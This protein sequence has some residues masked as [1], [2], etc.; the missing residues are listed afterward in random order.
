MS[1]H[2]FVVRGD[3]TRFACDAWLIPTGRGREITRSFWSPRDNLSERLF[4][5][6]AFLAAPGRAGTAAA[7]EASG[8][9]LAVPVDRSRSKVLGPGWSGSSAANPGEPFPG[10]SSSSGGP[11]PTRIGSCTR[12][13]RGSWPSRSS[14][15]GPEAST[16][17]QAPSSPNCCRAL[18]LEA[19]RLDVDIALVAFSEP[20]HAA[21]QAVRRATTPQ[22]WWEGLGG[23]AMEEARRLGRFAA[24]GRLV[25][26]F[27]AGLSMGVGLPVV[28][29]PSGRPR[30]GGRH[31]GR[32]APTPL[33]ARRSRLRADCGPA[34]QGRRQGEGE[35]I[36][37]LFA[38]HGRYG[39]SHGAL[40]SLPVEEFITT[41]YDVLF[42]AASADAGRPVAVLPYAPDARGGRW[43]LKMHGC[44]NH[45]DDVVLTR[46]SYLRYAERNA[47]LAGIVQAMLI[48]R[49]MLFLGFSLSD[50]NFHRIVDAVRRALRPGTTVGAPCS[51]RPSR[52][53]P[54]DLLEHLWKGEIDALRVPDGRSV[55]IF[56]DRLAFEAT[57][58]SHLLD[59]R[60]DALLEESDLALNALLRPLVQAADGLPAESPAWPLVEDLLVRLGA[61][62]PTTGARA[63]R[64]D[65]S[66]G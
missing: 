19:E 16:R 49:R 58:P 50:D 45:P 43:L 48:T 17:L 20:D 14:G 4:A 29:R 13:G 15:R 39:L 46:E 53:A 1:G 25:V 11:P 26:F 36:A 10:R 40:A 54:S 22:A 31:R 35:T 32:A 55:E 38:P 63:R 6:R 64:P 23:P 65:G 42:E 37:R 61:R 60:F 28:D 33:L 3:L 8:D 18:R 5:A 2:V 24:R 34:P 52:V 57:R 59:N 47:A 21:A 12:V 30:G 51:A 62:A 9:S 41:N 7:R 66:R 44:V 56:L 27:G